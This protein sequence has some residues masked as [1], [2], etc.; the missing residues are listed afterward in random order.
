V[1]KRNVLQGLVLALALG[2]IFAF[3]V[4]PCFAQETYTITTYYPS[5]YG[6]YNQLQTNRLAV[7]D[8]NN[9]GGLD[10]GDQPNNNGDIRLKAHTS[11][12]PAETGVV[13]E[14]AYASDGYLYVHNGST[15]VAQ[16]GGSGGVLYLACA[17]GSDYSTGANSGWG[18]QCGADGTACCTPPSCP[19]GWTSVATYPEPVSVACPNYGNVGCEWE[20]VSGGHHPVA[21]GRTVRACVK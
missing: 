7:G 9:S 5:P 8:T 11:A 18:N 4:S 17:W 12:P 14:V 3:G 19:T 10:A 15:W 6:S 1:F 13:G 2:L 16:A 21:V 20:S